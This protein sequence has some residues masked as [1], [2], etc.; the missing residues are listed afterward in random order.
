VAGK[1]E[2]L[3][4]CSKKNFSVT[5]GASKLFKA[6]LKLN[7]VEVVSYCDLRW[8]TGKLYENLGFSKMHRTKP[9]YFYTDGEN[10]F[11]RFKF[12]KDKLISSGQA[13]NKTEKQIM[14]E[15]GYNRI[16]DLGHYLYT[17]RAKETNGSNS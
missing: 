12:R 5:G 15:L 7:P 1:Y 14:R 4:L 16:Y 3:R 17:Y 6:F 10:L 2:L 9:N 11:N 8:G 13:A